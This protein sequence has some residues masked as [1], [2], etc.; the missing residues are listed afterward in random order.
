L[1]SESGEFELLRQLHSVSGKSDDSSA[2]YSACDCKEACKKMIG[3]VVK[4][5]K[6]NSN[7]ELGWKNADTTLHQFPFTS[8]PGLL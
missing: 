5:S 6:N 1:A 7:L 4:M 2:R 8:I 3:S